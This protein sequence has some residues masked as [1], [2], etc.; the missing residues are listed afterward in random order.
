MP[1]IEL[2][3]QRLSDVAR[4]LEASGHGLALLGLGSVGTE[5]DRLDQWS[6][7]DFFAVVAPGHKAAFLADTAWLGAACPVAWIFRNT[8]DGFKLLWAD[9]VFGEMAVFEPAELADVPYAPG[10][11]VWAAPGFDTSLLEPRN[12]GGQAGGITMEHAVGE[13]VSCLYVGLCRY[14]RGEK[15]SAWRFIQ[16]YCLDR[17]LEIVELTAAPGIARRD[18]YSRDRR[19]EQRYPAAAGRL[20]DILGGYGRTP[21]AALALLGWLEGLGPVN[22]ALAAEIRRLAAPA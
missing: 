22:A 4:A 19:F 1:T 5:T 10:R 3:N 14:R 9:G 18:R 13:L 6:D 2:L 21:E 16:G 11:A 15:L 12:Q 17:Y 8:P 20:E 7:L